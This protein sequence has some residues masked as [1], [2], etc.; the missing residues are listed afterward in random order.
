ME[1]INKY[2]FNEIPLSLYEPQWG[3]S[4]ATTIIELEKLR[5]KELGG[6]VPPHI[7]FQIKKLI[8]IFLQIFLME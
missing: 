6:P 3:S 4:L 5:V 7:F 8:Q 1:E 2:L